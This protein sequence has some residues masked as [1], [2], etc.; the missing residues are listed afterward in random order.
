MT[1]YY[2]CCQGI[3]IRKNGTKS[4][5]KQNY[6]CKDCHRQFVGAID[7]SKKEAKD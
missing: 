5:G 1:L 7:N 6:L 3:N 2:P 4:Y